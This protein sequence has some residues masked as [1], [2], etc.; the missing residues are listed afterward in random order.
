MD[1]VTYRGDAEQ[2]S[3][4]AETIARS[5]FKWGDITTSVQVLYAVPPDENEHDDLIPFA[6]TENTTAQRDPCGRSDFSWMYL[7]PD[8]ATFVHD[9]GGMPD[10]RHPDSPLHSAMDVIHHELGHVV[11][12]KFNPEDVVAIGHCFGRDIEDWAD[13]KALPWGERTLEAFCETFKDLYLGDNRQW[14]NRTNLRLRNDEFNNLLDVLDHVCPCLGSDL[15]PEQAGEWVWVDTGAGGFA[16]FVG[17]EPPSTPILVWGENPV[18][19]QP[20]WEDLSA[21]VSA[22]DV[23]WFEWDFA[24]QLGDG[25]PPFPKLVLKYDFV[26]PV[27]SSVIAF[28]KLTTNGRKGRR[29]AIAPANAYVRFRPVLGESTYLW[30]TDA[31]SRGFLRVY[32]MEGDAWAVCTPKPRPAWPYG[33]DPPPDPDPPPPPPPPPPTISTRIFYANGGVRRYSRG[34]VL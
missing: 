31:F 29:A 12:A 26:D 10:K 13:E 32:R 24:P 19:E 33:G 11:A 8:L 18:A 27:D 5:S 25:T 1:F 3:W 9:F 2:Q 15:P 4:A 17:P 22:G 23:L 6:T 34:G 7:R 14:D 20:H 16:N 30:G 28:T 21:S